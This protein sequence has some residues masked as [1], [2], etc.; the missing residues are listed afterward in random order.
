MGTLA[1]EVLK[2]GRLAREGA[3]GGVRDPGA[4]ELWDIDFKPMADL[5]L[6]SKNILHSTV[7][8]FNF[9]IVFIKSRNNEPLL[10]FIGK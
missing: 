10:Q 6:F 5:C 4:K 2:R 8:K 1:R 3:A 7:N 9:D